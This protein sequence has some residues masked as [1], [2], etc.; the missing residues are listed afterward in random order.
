M[1][2][3]LILIVSILSAACNAD[4][5]LAARTQLHEIIVS[6]TDSN[7]V[8]QLYHINEDGSSRRQITDSE[9]GCV[10][11]AVSPDGRKLFRF[12]G[13]NSDYLDTDLV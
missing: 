2:S 13:S 10:M 6:H 3:L 12:L 11:P 5:A 4:G 7:N 8:L 1:R 9:H